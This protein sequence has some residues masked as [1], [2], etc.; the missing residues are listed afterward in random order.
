MSL[1]FGCVLVCVMKSCVSVLRFCVSEM[2]LRWEPEEYS[3]RFGDYLTNGH[4]HKATTVDGVFGI[5][6]PGRKV[7]KLKK[8]RVMPAA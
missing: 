6:I 8:A 3:K 1:R 2:Q 4:G 5:L 7:W